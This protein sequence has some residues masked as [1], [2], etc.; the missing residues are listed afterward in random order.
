MEV[1]FV[2]SSVS[3]SVVFPGTKFPYLNSSI[4]VDF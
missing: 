1:K 3:V 4:M 2:Y